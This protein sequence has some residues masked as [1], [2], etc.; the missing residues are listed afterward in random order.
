MN[1]NLQV[2]ELRLIEHAK[3]GVSTVLE[4]W[5][6][7]MNL[8]NLALVVVCQT[9]VHDGTDLDGVENCTI[10]FGK[11]LAFL[12]AGILVPEFTVCY[13]AASD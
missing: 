6:G 2:R 3:Y 11:D 4:R 12:C 1:T 5:R 8:K 7:H 10:I 13:T 9:F